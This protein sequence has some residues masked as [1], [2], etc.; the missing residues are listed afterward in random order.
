M[1]RSP[2][3]VFPVGPCRAALCAAAAAP[4]RARAVAQLPSGEWIEAADCAARREAPAPGRDALHVRAGMPARAAAWAPSSPRLRRP[5]A[6]GGWEVEASL[7]GRRA[8]GRQ[9]AGHC[10]QGGAACAWC[11]AHGGSELMEERAPNPPSDRPGRSLS[12]SPPHDAEGRFLPP[13]MLPGETPRFFSFCAEG[14]V[15]RFP[16]PHGIP[17]ALP[18]AR[19]EA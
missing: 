11:S 4:V 5:R 9:T 2:T 3:P 14:R 13:A 10:L 16:A 1:T 6:D 19:A 15:T 17:A 8:A 12:P 18:H 7:P